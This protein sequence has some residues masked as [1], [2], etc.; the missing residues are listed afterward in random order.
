MDAGG[1]ALRSAKKR[2]VEGEKR[3]FLHAKLERKGVR[4]PGRG[5]PAYI[6]KGELA[7]GKGSSPTEE[8]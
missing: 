5:Q 6:A 7:G 1:V 8:I 3:P 4:L 2:T